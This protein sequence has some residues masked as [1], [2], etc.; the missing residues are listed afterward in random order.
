MRH[1][2]HGPGRAAVIGVLIAGCLLLGARIRPTTETA[3]TL[4]TLRADVQ[5]TVRDPDRAG[6]A[7]A[8]LDSVNALVPVFVAFQSR[9]SSELRGLLRDYDTT[10]ADFEQAA[11]RWEVDRAELRTR[12]LAAHQAFKQALTDAE[13]KKLRGEER[14]ILLRYPV[15]QTQAATGVVEEGR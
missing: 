11:A 7:L 10:R 4:A 15:V 6:R 3:A 8:A 12:A 1:G 13:W 9:T 14:N 2:T 5:E